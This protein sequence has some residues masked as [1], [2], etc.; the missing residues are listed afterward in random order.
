MELL[1]DNIQK[2]NTILQDGNI[3]E[4]LD[5]FKFVIEDCK[6]NYHLKLKI[7]D[8]DFFNEETLMFL[9]KFKA[10]AAEMK[11]FELAANARWMELECLNALKNKAEKNLVNSEFIVTEYWLIFCCFEQTHNINN[12]KNALLKFM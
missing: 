3:L 9:K 7:W 6:N 8:F 5:E 12:I 11:N 10:K 4:K 2:L 1:S